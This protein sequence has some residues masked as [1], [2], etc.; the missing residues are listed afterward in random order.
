MGDLEQ[1]VANWVRAEWNFRL[2]PKAYRGDTQE[3]LLEAEKQLRQ[4]LT[5]K[6]PLDKAYM[7]LTQ[8]DA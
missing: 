3:M 1:A 5:G 7:K 8:Q 2:G 4:A 6:R